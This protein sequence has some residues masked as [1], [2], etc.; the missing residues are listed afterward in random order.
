MDFKNAIL[1][2]RKRCKLN[3]KNN[4]QIFLK[5]EILQVRKINKRTKAEMFKELK[6]GDKITIEIEIKEAG[7]NKASYASY[8][9]ITNLKTEEF[10][11]KTFNTL[12]S[13]L[14][15]FELGEV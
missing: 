12:P 8:L 11:Y 7:R 4:N 1:N 5:S 3:K 6:V 10:T 2:S 13:I 14:S 9:K 15:N